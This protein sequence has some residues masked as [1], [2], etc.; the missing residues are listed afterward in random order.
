MVRSLE[1][2]ALGRARCYESMALADLLGVPADKV[3]HDRLYRTLD[4]ILPHKVALEKHLKQRL[5]ELFQMEYDLL[6]YD[7]TSTYFGAPGKAWRFQRVRFPH[8]QGASHLTGNRA[9]G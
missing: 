8:R 7:L 2:T 9:L 4:R 1:R 6:L 3:N 5:G